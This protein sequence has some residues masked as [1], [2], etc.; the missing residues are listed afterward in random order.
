MHS[1]TL[2]EA[3]SER[4]RIEREFDPGAI[5]TLKEASA[6]DLTIDGPTLA[7]RALRA[8]LVDALRVYVCPVIVGGGNAFYPPGVRLDL[9]LVGERRF[10]NGVVYL[11]YVV[12]A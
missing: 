9:E 10:G 2:A 1:S 3:A 8:G 4:T 5:R 12:R 7:A 6:A 11:N